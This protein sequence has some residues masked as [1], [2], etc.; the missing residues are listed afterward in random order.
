M[1]G[2]HDLTE[3]GDGRALPTDHVLHLSVLAA[4]S[5]VLRSRTSGA[6][7]DVDNPVLDLLDRLAGQA[8]TGVAVIVLLVV[9]KS[10]VDVATTRRAVSR[11]PSP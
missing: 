5:L 3:A 2:G 1:A 4:F 11:R 10:L 6:I 7:G 8:G 9:I